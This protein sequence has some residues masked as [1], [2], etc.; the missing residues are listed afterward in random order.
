MNQNKFKYF[1]KFKKTIYQFKN[2]RTKI[3]FH[4]IKIQGLK[5]Y[6]S[7]VDT[8][9]LLFQLFSISYDYRISTN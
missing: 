5:T 3:M 2:I 7:Y 1:Q 6:F 9:F 8:W 4:K